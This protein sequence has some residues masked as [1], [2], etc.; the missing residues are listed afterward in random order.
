MGQIVGRLPNTWDRLLQEKDRVLYWSGEVL[1]QV[2][3]NVNQEMS[4][5]IDYGEESIDEKVESWMNRNRSRVDRTIA[6]YPN[7][8]AQYKTRVQIELAKIR[9][10]FRIRMR[11][12]YRQ[13]YTDIKNF[14]R[15]VDKLGKRQRKI[16]GK[17]LELE[18]I[19]DGDVKRFQKKL[20]PLRVKTFENLRTGEKM[21]FEDK[22]LKTKFAKRVNEID[23]KNLQECS[24]YVDKLISNIEDIMRN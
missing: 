3:D 11:N 2:A 21:T 17:I 22:R 15:K 13:A 7:M 18:T 8:A 20:G 12:D 6:K 14:T 24:K 23:L 10:G 9:E 4:L 1:A 5:F 19:C 16:H